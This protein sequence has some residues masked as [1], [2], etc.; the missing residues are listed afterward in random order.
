MDQV[1]KMATFSPMNLLVVDDESN[2]RK[3]MKMFFDLQHH[4]V[5]TVSTP[6]DA[7]LEAGLQIF[8]LAFVDIR[9]GLESGL[10]LV[11]SLLA[12]SPW[13]KIVVIT[14][15][16]SVDTAVE[17]MKRG[18]VDYLP[19]P[20]MP[21]QLK[22]VLER[23]AA[24]R[25][26][27]Q[28]INLLQD[29]LDRNDPD[30]SLN[31]MYPPM[32]RVIELARQVSTS[33]AVVMLLGPSG[34]GKTMLAKLIHR[35]SHRSDK[36]FGVISCPSLS[37]ELLESELFGHVKGAFTGALRENPG[38]VASCEGG[39]LFL[40]EIGE[41][42]LSIQSKLLRFLQ[43]REYER[44]GDQRTRKANVRIIAATNAD[45][46]SAVA[47]GTFR[48][49]LYY[50]L[51]VIQITLPSL[52]E[53]CGDIAEIAANMLAFFNAE[54]HKAIQGFSPGVLKIFRDYGW[55]GNIRELRNVVERAV[56]LCTTSMIGVELLP[57]SMASVVQPQIMIGDRIKLEKIEELHIRRVLASTSSVQEA[58]EVLEIDKA[59][60]WRKRKQFGI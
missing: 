54:N 41:L 29:D 57:D 32:Q 30:I 35:W 5:T 34:S 40:D 46:K 56:I 55:P 3:T 13:L 51:D 38:R 49:D 20:F 11:S 26:L 15:F 9:L 27:E 50:R 2:I 53:R 17:A 25:L 37:Q 12:R 44:V 8:D 60:L 52:S 23:V 14:A 42:P 4:K 48:E 7:L 31:S 22:L 16:A 6:K 1:E 21:D 47:S 19:K 24:I 36:P 10:D 18:A 33:D 59:T 45:L 39:T 28:R 58:A 43:E